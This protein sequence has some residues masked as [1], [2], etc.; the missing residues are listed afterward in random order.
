MVRHDFN[1]TVSVIRT[2][3]TEG[4]NSEIEAYI[5]DYFKTQAISQTMI[6][7]GNS[8]VDA[9]I[10]SKLSEAQQY[11]IKVSVSTINDLESK[12]N[13]DLCSLFGNLLDNAIRASKQS[14]K[15]VINLDIRRD[16]ESIAITVKNTIDSSVL[17]KNPDLVSDKQDKKK[18]GY[19]TKIIREIAKKYSGFAD[20][21]EE[22]G[23]FCCN[24]MLYLG[25]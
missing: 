1:N 2:L 7:T 4:K 20:F 6:K 19:G 22:D 3:N 25:D 15:K 21:Y 8:Y 17:A 14:S 24:V 16:M 5:Q 23:Y 18:H 12:H 9:V 11:G 10:N 13:I